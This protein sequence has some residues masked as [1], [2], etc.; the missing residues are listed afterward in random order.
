ML[1]SLSNIIPSKKVVSMICGCENGDSTILFSAMLCGFIGSRQIRRTN[2]P[3]CDATLSNEANLAIN[4]WRWR[5]HQ[6]SPDK[7][8]LRFFSIPRIILV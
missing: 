7:I 5:E 3:E 8:Y 6:N 2:N 4:R 1:N